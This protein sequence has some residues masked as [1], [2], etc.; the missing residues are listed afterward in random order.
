MTTFNISVIASIET[1]VNGE[2]EY[3]NTSF[4]FDYSDATTWEELKTLAQDN[5]IEEIDAEATNVNFEDVTIEVDNPDDWDGLP[6]KY[7]DLESSD[8]W[9][10][11]DACYNSDNDSDIVAA[12]LESGVSP[13]DIDEAYHGTFS[14]GKDFAQEMAEQLGAIDKDAK[15]P[16]TCI[17]WEQAASELMMDYSEHNGH[18]FRD[19]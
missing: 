14:S 10:F 3:F 12:G 7:R 13:S 6:E 18:Y 15:W 17:D 8:F 19:L 1:E 9:E 2:Q 11:L 4:S 5:L 16:M